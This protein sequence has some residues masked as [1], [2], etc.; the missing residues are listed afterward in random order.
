MAEPDTVP[1]ILNVCQHSHPFFSFFYPATAELF[2]ILLAALPWLA[3]DA[4]VSA[5]I[6]FI[7]FRPISSKASVTRSAVF[8]DVSTNTMSLPFANF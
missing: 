6:F 3:V 2:Y 1:V 5:L 7:I 4:L 8:A